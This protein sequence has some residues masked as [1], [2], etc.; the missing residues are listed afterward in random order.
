MGNVFE[1]EF[2]VDSFLL[3]MKHG[4]ETLKRSWVSRRSQTCLDRS[5]FA[6]ERSHSD[7]FL[8]RSQIDD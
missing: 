2:S 3:E 4:S 1:R 8:D 7:R 5:Q 6:F